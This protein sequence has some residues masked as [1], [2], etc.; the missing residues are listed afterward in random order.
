MSSKTQMSPLMTSC[1]QGNLKEV[2]EML[3]EPLSEKEI[4]NSL[5]MCREGRSH[6]PENENYDLII[7]MILINH[8]N[9]IIPD[10]GQYAQSVLL[11]CRGPRARYTMYEN[12]N[13]LGLVS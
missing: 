9:E 2:Q 10:S 1:Y 12:G 11:D 4:Y 3:K 13:L 7:S 8:P 5:V 6:C